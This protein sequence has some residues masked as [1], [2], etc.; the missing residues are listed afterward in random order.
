MY[1]S[2]DTDMIQL[3]VFL[4]VQQK[5]VH[6]DTDSI[7]PGNELGDRD[8]SLPPMEVHKSKRDRII[9]TSRGAPKVKI[10]QVPIF[11]FVFFF[12]FGVVHF[13]IV[14]PLAECQCDQA[15]AL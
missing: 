4:S 6:V 14:S 13:I 3:Y 2:V 12:F 5:S 11:S 9:A 1:L 15:R 10:E 7:P 8:V